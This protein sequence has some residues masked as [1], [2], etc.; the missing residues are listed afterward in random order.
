MVRPGRHGDLPAFPTVAAILLSL[1]LSSCSQSPRPRVVA[2]VVPRVPAGPSL[3]D[4][5]SELFYSG[6]KAALSGDFECAEAEFQ[7]ALNAVVP[8]AGPRPEAAD[9]T[10][11]SASL[12]ESIRRYEAMAQT[13]A[14]ADPQEARDTPDELVGV[15]DQN[16]P[17]D[18]A[19]AREEVKTDDRA[20]AFDLPIAVNEQ[21]LNMVASFSSRPGVRHRFEEGLQRAGRYMPMIRSV[22]EREGLPRDLA[23]VAMIESSFK[24]RARS[25]ARAQ[26]VWQFI[27]ATGRRY[28]LHRTAAVDERSDPVKAT[29]AAAGYFK[30]LHEIFND[31]YL[32][33]AAYD[34][35]E[36]RIARA[37]ARTGAETYWDLC[38]L[39]AIPRETRL[40]VPSVIAAALIDKNQ[41]HYG[42]HVQPESPV[43]FETVR[44]NKPVNVHRLA[45]TCRLNAEELL[46]L[47]PELRGSTTPKDPSGYELRVP[48]GAASLV[49]ERLGAIPAAAVPAF[50][51]H[52]VRKGETL[53]RV[54]RRYGVSLASLAEANDLSPRARL[55]P[56]RMLVIPERTA[57]APRRAR[58]AAERRAGAAAAQPAPSGETAYS[59]RKGDTLFSIATSHHTTVRK[60][61]EWNQL[62]ASNAIQ[63]GDRLTIAPGNR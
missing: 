30:D 45:Q 38:R 58:K 56:S 28:G 19:A 18:L 49:A 43:E 39:G 27:G 23:Y 37:L 20:S 21:V 60:L 26:G 53:A 8:P 22:L 55:A 59:V 15:S 7:L 14:E 34:A 54:A 42:F 10:E 33:M 41:A 13:A 9:V 32:A 25:R 40:Y 46:D 16:S 44:L 31:W 5:S 48:V 24:T 51:Q 35:G 11:F 1:T 12:Y 63:P 2:P 50:R 57:S 47:N 36:G 52:R 29:E 61:R 4:R 6:K 62:N 17:A 3:I